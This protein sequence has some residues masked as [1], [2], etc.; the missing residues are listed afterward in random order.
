MPVTT[1]TFDTQQSGRP[2]PAVY[3]YLEYRNG[4]GLDTGMTP[5]VIVVASDDIAPPN[6]TCARSVQLDMNPSTRP[7]E[8]MTEGQ[9][10]TDPAGGLSFTVTS[11][12]SALA[13]VTV[14]LDATAMP[15]TC[16][17]ETTLSG[18]GPVACTGGGDGG[19]GGTGNGGAGGSAGSTTNGTM[20][21]TT[22]GGA[23]GSGTSSST[24]GDVFDQQQPHQ[25][26]H[27]QWQHHHQRRQ[28]VDERFQC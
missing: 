21:S 24:G 10:Y 11:L 26:Q 27:H 12:T 5:S 1:R 20:S 8:G 9:T 13:T 3:Y 23:G 15:N 2:S 7:L 17:D 16:M 19:T 4:S 14:T 18:S 28:P 6:R 25:R 22:I